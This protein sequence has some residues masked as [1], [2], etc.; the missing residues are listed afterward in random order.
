MNVKYEFFFTN[1][2]VEVFDMKFDKIDLNMEPLPIKKEEPWILLESNQCKLCTLNRNDY[3]YCPVARNLSFVLL[4][5]KNDPSF[6]E[7][8]VR[9]TTEDRITEKKGTLQEGVSPLM[10]LIMATS[11]CPIL[12]KFKPMAFTHLP[13][14]NETETIFRAISMYL[15]AQY[16]RRIHGM[17]PDWQLEKFKEMYSQVNQINNDFAERVRKIK[18][19]DANINAL[20]LLDLF[21]QVGIFSFS[22][23]WMKELEPLFNAY[24][25]SVPETC[26]NSSSNP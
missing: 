22:E 13:F 18:G 9:V 4:I 23:D 3:N 11:G 12:D 26:I 7:V 17:E 14:S 24:L 2:R 21:A 10:G 19:K 8:T 16:F 6:E 25:G 1:D 5:F 15:T 20:I